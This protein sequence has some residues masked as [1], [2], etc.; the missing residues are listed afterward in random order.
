MQLETIDLWN[1]KCLMPCCFSSLSRTNHRSLFV[2]GNPEVEMEDE[3]V[4]SVH[5]ST[6]TDGAFTIHLKVHDEEEV[7]SCH[8]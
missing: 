2:P 7:E 5:V 4:C 6:L 8:W 1:V 3:F